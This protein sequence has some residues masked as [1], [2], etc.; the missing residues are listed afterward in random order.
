MRRSGWFWRIA[1]STVCDSFLYFRFSG[2]F[3]VLLIF[4]ETFLVKICVL[5]G[6]Y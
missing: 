5:H 3:F 6:A 4:D 1:W 2:E